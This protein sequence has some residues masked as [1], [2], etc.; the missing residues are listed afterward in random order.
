MPGTGDWAA[1]ELGGLVHVPAEL[2]R[3]P[4]KLVGMGVS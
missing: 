3:L 2:V 4:T 1:V